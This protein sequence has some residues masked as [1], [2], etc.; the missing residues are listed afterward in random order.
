MHKFGFLSTDTAA[1]NDENV[2]RRSSISDGKRS[3]ADWIKMHFDRSVLVFQLFYFFFY[4]AFGSL[5]P[6]ISIYFKQLGLSAI[7]CGVLSGIRYLIDWLA[8]PFWNALAEKWKKGKSFLIV[9]LVCSMSFTLGLGFVRPSPEGCLVR[10]PY[11]LDYNETL[12]NVVGAPL[13]IVEPYRFS[14]Y[15]DLKSVDMT[16]DLALNIKNKIGQSPLYLDIKLLA[17]N[18]KLKTK[19]YGRVMEQKFYSK[20]P[21]FR[22]PTHYAPGSLVM[23][24]YSTV[25]YSQTK[26]NQIFIIIILLVL[27]GELLSCP[28]IPLVDALVAL[29][30]SV[31]PTSLYGQQ[32][33]MGSVGWGLA[34]FFI[35]LALDNSSVFQD[36]PCLQPGYR[37]RNYLVCFATYSV[38]MAFALFT[39]T[40]FSFTY[41]GGQES[42]YFKLVK[43]KMAKTLLGRTTK[44]R[45]KL[46]NEED[47]D[48]D[49][50]NVTEH[51]VTGIS[52]SEQNKTI[53]TNEEILE[54]QLGIKLGSNE[55]RV[56]SK[57]PE[58]EYSS[59]DS[60]QE[61]FVATAHLKITKCA[62]AMRYFAKPQLL[63]FLFVTWF[64]GMGVGQ[65]FTFLFWHMQELNGS[66]TLFGVATV[67]NHISEI[68]MFFFSKQII[69][70]IGH[71][72]VLYLGLLG[73]VIRFL[74]VS[75]ITNPWWILPFEFLQGFTHAGVWVACCSYIT[76]AFPM[77]LRSTTQGFLQGVHYGLGRGLGACFGGLVISAYG[78]ATMFRSYGAASAVVLIGFLLLNYFMP[79]PAAESDIIPE[80]TIVGTDLDCSGAATY[81]QPTERQTKVQFGGYQVAEVTHDYYTKQLTQ[82]QQ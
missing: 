42:M 64:M 73:N 3:W 79:I 17:D 80:G 66:P 31:Q 10:L 60:G 57:N 2:Q 47:P 33:M 75:W 81:G 30:T 1:P 51:N 8:T 71:L 58:T 37:E 40:Q 78:S 43:D 5:F 82:Q 61:S 52:K 28:A 41:E 36:Y 29:K 69:D 45:S 24:L 26:I 72:K 74:Y 34:M 14:T 54:R 59:A 44:N 15:D 16:R 7:Q 21:N 6:L 11:S 13:A 62:K 56:E 4:A 48:E 53:P 63:L 22:S 12:D 76:Q 20:V 49:D 9:S 65:V 18:P 67:I 27:F 19:G 70:K 35:G 39:S 23:P 50:P 38:F 25:V 46:V 68:V 32:R 77:E 55:K